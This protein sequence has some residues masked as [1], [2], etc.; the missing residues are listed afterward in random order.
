MPFW[1]ADIVKRMEESGKGKA[2][3]EKEAIDEGIKFLKNMM[4][5][6]SASYSGKDKVVPKIA[7]KRLQ[8][9]KLTF[10]QVSKEH[11]R[12]I[13]RD[14]TASPFSGS[15]TSQGDGKDDV[16]EAM[17]EPKRSHKRTIKTG[18]TIFISHD[19]LKSPVL[20]SSNI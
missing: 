4:N 12:K 11:N 6:R 2:A 17:V 9:Q 3:K 13:R 7:E 15:E 14:K 16:S 19:I 10:A 18:T 1:P 5:D 20:V 8:K